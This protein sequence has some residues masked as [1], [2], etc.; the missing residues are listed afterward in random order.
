LENANLG[1][2]ERLERNL[3]SWGSRQKGK[4][5]AMGRVLDAFGPCN[6]TLFVPPCQRR[7]LRTRSPHLREAVGKGEV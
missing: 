1:V 3:E 4:K 5:R 7:L 6:S 2:V